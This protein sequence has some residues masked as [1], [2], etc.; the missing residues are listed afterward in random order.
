LLVFKLLVLFPLVQ[1]VVAG[2]RLAEA[3]WLAGG[4][5]KGPWSKLIRFSGAGEAWGLCILFL[6]LSVVAFGVFVLLGEPTSIA[7][8]WLSGHLVDGVGAFGVHVSLPWLQTALDIAAALF[9]LGL[10]WSILSEVG[11]EGLLRLRSLGAL[12][13]A[14]C[15]CLALLAFGTVIA[16]GA[17]LAVLHADLAE[18]RPAVSPGGELEAALEWHAWHLAEALPFFDI[19]SAL[20]W[21]PGH[22]FAGRADGIVVLALRLVFFL[23]LLVPVAWLV[24]A[25]VHRLRPPAAAELGAFR[26]LVQQLRTMHAQLDE[27]QAGILAERERREEWFREPVDLDAPFDTFRGITPPDQEVYPKILRAQRRIGRLE[28]PLERVHALFG[29][30]EASTAADAAVAAEVAR[31]EVLDR[32]HWSPWSVDELRRT[33]EPA[34]AEAERAV[35]ALT[36]AATAALYDTAAAGGSVPA[37]G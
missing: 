5:R 2:Y 24:R 18:A 13:G 4:E 35:A 31:L 12:A 7:D 19:P 27:I 6:W 14:M 29:P 17:T 33:F 16:G 37:V 34:Q 21:S 22:K 20:A 10:F 30:G 1:V 11:G 9:S 32:H 36:D 23:V 25:T 26:D 15:A 28:P 8:R 3:R